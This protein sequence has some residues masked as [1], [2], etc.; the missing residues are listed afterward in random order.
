MPLS[1]DLVSQFAKVTD[2]SKVVHKENRLRG[3]IVRNGDDL[4]VRIDGSNVDTPVAKADINGSMITK[5]A[6]GN[7]ITNDTT[8]DLSEGDRVEVEIKNHTAVVT[9]NMTNPSLGVVEADGFRSE[10][11]QTAKEIRLEVQELANGLSS[12]IDIQAGQI[13]SLV[14]QGSEF[15]KFQQTLS[16]FKFINPEGETL[17]DGSHIDTS[18]IKLTWDSDNSPV[19]VRY[20]ATGGD[21]ESEWHDELNV[22]EDYYAQYSYDGGKTY[23]DTIQIRGK[24]GENGE[25]GENGKDA[26]V[27]YDKIV[28]ELNKAYSIEAADFIYMGKGELHSPKIYSGTIYGASIY[29]GEGSSTF[30]SLDDNGLK[31]YC[32][33]LDDPKIEMGTNDVGNPIIFKMGAGD[34]NETN[35]FEIRKYAG[36]GSDDDEVTVTYYTR[37]HKPIGFRFDLATRTIYVRGKLMPE[38]QTVDHNGYEI[39]PSAIYA[40]FA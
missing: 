13:E 1:S 14:Q 39:P 31:L 7:S 4:C 33:S 6:D 35:Y 36:P 28:S 38:T 29:A 10:I 9:G 22:D 27:T 30:T 34:V 18:S 32:H 19:K 2:D 8:V 5:D 24:D 26:T 15:S 12:S 23:T 3:T 25:N 40:T 21:D 17:I 11:S 37:E 20:S 16:G